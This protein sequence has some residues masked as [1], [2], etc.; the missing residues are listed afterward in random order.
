M[1]RQLEDQGSDEKGLAVDE[2]L[3]GSISKED[4]EVITQKNGIRRM[5][6]GK[7]GWGRL[8]G[9]SKTGRWE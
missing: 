5:N 2:L 6:N 4:R 1:T 8:K 7:R 3:E 9:E